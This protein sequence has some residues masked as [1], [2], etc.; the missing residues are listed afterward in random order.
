MAIE[1]QNRVSLATQ[2]SKQFDFGHWLVLAGGFA[3]VVMGPTGQP[4]P[5]RSLRL[6]PAACSPSMLI[7]T[8][9]TSSGE[10]VWRSWRAARRLHGRG[11]TRRGG[12]EREARGAAG[13]RKREAGSAAAPPPRGDA[14][15][16]P[17]CSSPPF[18]NP[19]I[20]GE[21]GEEGES[22]PGFL[23]WV[24]PSRRARRGQP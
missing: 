3:D 9:C 4:P 5:Q 21:R 8:A 14:A 12:R 7:P 11:M 23:M 17:P 1:L 24:E 16:P 18:F 22:V 10:R 19:K 2:L 20:P 15:A 6:L 13:R